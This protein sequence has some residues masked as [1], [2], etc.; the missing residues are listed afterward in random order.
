M[1]KFKL[2]FVIFLL[3]F[4]VAP[5]A[6]HAL[7]Y[8]DV[9]KITLEND[10]NIKI[11]RNTAASYQGLAITAKSTFDPSLTATISDGYQYSP[12]SPLKN[13]NM[14]LNSS[15]GYTQKFR[16]GLS[17]TPQV[18]LA[19]LENYT[20]KASANIPN[21]MQA[22]VLF[23]KPLLQASSEYIITAKEQ[24]AGLNYL[25]AN[26]TLKYQVN[27]SI[28]NSLTQYWAVLYYKLKINILTEAERDAKK[29]LLQT[30]ISVDQ[31]YQPS[32]DI[33]QAEANLYDRIVAKI[34]AEQAFLSALQNL[35]IYMGLPIDAAASIKINEDKFPDFGDFPK[36]FLQRKN[37]YLE[38]ALKNRSDY[39][40]SQIQISSSKIAVDAAKDL[41]NPNLSLNASLGYSGANYKSNFAVFTGD[42]VGANGTVYLSLDL[43]IVNNNAEGS[44][45]SA[46]SIYEKYQ[47]QQSL[48]KNTIQ[49]TVNQSMENINKINAQIKMAKNASSY[50]KITVE[51]EREKLRLG[52]STLQN[53]IIMQ[54]K[55]INSQLTYL[56][57]I[58]NY[59]SA[60]AKIHYDIQ[61]VVSLQDS[62]INLNLEDL[63]RIP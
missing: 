41:Y 45:L 1:K 11:Q 56:G 8:L 23:S 58:Y 22:S 6:V 38:T 7:T 42:V 62:G 49:F 21:S 3:L 57:V 29:I 47:N 12:L 4:S 32:S 61:S 51:N 2:L 16:H 60:L 5:I 33:D 48:L 46:K 13:T 55:C 63:I 35:G 31:D 34:Q 20:G 25:A 18:S 30:K 43:P 15:L 40:S 39:Q 52:L 27:S 26:E 24:I 14:Q 28:Y 50:Y 53:V 59:F 10:P 36:D 54:D 17:I 19:H 9:I 44:Y 37:V